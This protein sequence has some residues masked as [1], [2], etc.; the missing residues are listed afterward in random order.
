MN[1][2][3]GISSSFGNTRELFIPV[4]GMRHMKKPPED[5]ALNY[6]KMIGYITSSQA[7]DE[8][9]ADQKINGSGF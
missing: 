3:H 6:L 8:N 4:P 9:N 1:L 2:R 7:G 5:A